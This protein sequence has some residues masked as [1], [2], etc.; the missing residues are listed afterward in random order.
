V[1]GQNKWFEGGAV[2]AGSG[3]GGKRHLINARLENL[4]NLASAARFGRVADAALLE[5]RKSAAFS[6]AEALAAVGLARNMEALRRSR[7]KVSEGH[8]ALQARNVPILVGTTG[9]EIEK[10]AAAPAADHDVRVDRAKIMLESMRREK[11]RDD[12]TS[13]AAARS[14]PKRWPGM[15]PGLR[16]HVRR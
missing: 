8:L 4:R 6:L 1:E 7:W 12:R 11:V 9:D 2:V 5:I 15:F 10:V 13:F 14:D 3:R 16:V